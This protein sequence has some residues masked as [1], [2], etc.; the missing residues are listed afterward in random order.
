MVNAICQELILRKNEITKPIETIYFGGGTPS[1]LENEELE[2]IFETIYHNFSVLENAEITI[3]ANPDDLTMD[4]IIALS[5]TKINRLSIG[6]Q[7]FNDKDLLLMNRVHNSQ[8]AINSLQNAQKYFKNI[9]IDLIYGMPNSTIVDWQKNIEK[10]LSF[11]IPHISCY[12]LTVEPKTALQK[13]IATKKI[14]PINDESAHDQFM[15]L[16]EILENQGFIHYEMSN[17]G[18]EEFFS[19]N[20]TAYWTGKKYVGIGPSA[21]SFDG[22]K[23]SWNIA[24]N[25]KFINEINNGILPQEFEILTQKDLY[26]EYLMTALRTMQGVCFKKI[27]KDFGL[28]VLAILK[29]NSQKYIDLKLLTIENDFLKTTKNGKFLSDGIISDLFLLHL[30]PKND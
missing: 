29:K 27:E 5:K 4:K 7:S 8:E 13:M 9:T 17:F 14:N 25:I 21:H 1:L 26:N 22:K 10:A 28:D 20:N 23:R 11:N 30:K 18:K 19:Q 2:L 24:N 12:A 15:Y 6:I 3:E 16:T